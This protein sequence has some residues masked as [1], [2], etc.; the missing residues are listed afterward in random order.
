M[1]V[2]S[3]QIVGKTGV[4]AFIFRPRPKGSYP[5]VVLLHERYGLVKH[6]TDLAERL[7]DSGY[8]V[9]TP[10]LFYAYP[11]QESL[12]R[13]EVGVRL[14]DAEV[15]EQIDDVRS[16]LGQ[17]QGCDPE[18][19]AVMGVCQSGRYSIVYGAKRSVASCITFYGAAQKSDWE[20]NEYQPES[21][22][23]LIEDIS[24]PMLGIFGEKD[25]V[26][27]ISDVANLRDTFE[28]SRKSYRIIV[29][30]DAPHGWLNDTMI[31]R[32]R[33]GIAAMAW[34]ELLSYLAETLS[35]NG[36]WSKVRWEFRSAT[37][38]D[39]NF[40]SNVRLE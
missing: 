27:S 40:S 22:G 29:Y 18:R 7:A 32:Y 33:P 28:K 3:E 36:N 13:G 30:P 20:I 37:S 23:A 9:V 24:A 31:G 2:I 5:C 6:T 10:D 15:V 14:T 8:V 21:L 16:V 39:Y 38:Q 34:S 17:V 11:D 4:P 35:G 26:I 19:L 1:D 12:R 25:H